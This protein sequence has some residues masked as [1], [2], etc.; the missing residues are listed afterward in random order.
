MRWSTQFIKETTDALL[1]HYYLLQ[2]PLRWLYGMAMGVFL[3]AANCSAAQS[4]WIPTPQQMV[5]PKPKQLVNDWAGLLTVQQQQM[6]ERKLVA[7]SDS[8]SVQIAVLTLPELNG[9]D[10]AQLAFRIG[11]AWGIGGAQQDNGLLLLISK[12]ERA[13]FI[14]TGKGMEAVVPDVLAKR[15]VDYV[16]IPAF[17]NE[18]YFAGIEQASA[19][20]M[21]LTR[22][23]FVDELSST[24]RMEFWQTIVLILVVALFV[25]YLMRR[26]NRGGFIDRR[27][28]HPRPW[29]DIGRAYTFWPRGGLGGGLGGFGGFGGGSFG[30]GGAGGRW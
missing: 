12:K 24:E 29:I 20:I 30:G 13:V 26:M 14:A 27:G 3:F 23:E 4:G 21:A 10:I 11:D 1:R 17:R 18:N 5:P 9:F 25:L 16:L 6:L 19:V 28:W 2:L 8:T 15:I 7:F 22:G